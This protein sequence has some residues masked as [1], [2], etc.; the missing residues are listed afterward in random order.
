VHPRGGD[1][2]PYVYVLDALVGGLPAAGHG[3]AIADAAEAA[4]APHDYVI[5]LR[6]RECR[7]TGL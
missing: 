5:E 4:G 7:S 3:G 6:S 2:V 1:V